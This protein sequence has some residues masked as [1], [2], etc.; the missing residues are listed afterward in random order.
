MSVAVYGGYQTALYYAVLAAQQVGHLSA[1]ATAI[2]FLPMGGASI[3]L[4]I[5]WGKLVQVV[6]PKVL[7]IFGMTMSTVAPVPACLNFHETISLYVCFSILSSSLVQPLS[8]CK[9]VQLDQPPSHVN[10]RDCRHLPV[11]DDRVH[12]H[13][14]SRPGQR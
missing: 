14:V 9:L 13:V 10:P 11:L 3:I 7:L 6:N 1:T 8:E 4:S 12:G 2:H 5:I